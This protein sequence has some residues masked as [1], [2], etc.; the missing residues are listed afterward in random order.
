V[1]G[2]V[3]CM[4]V[5][6]GCGDDT[7]AVD[8]FSVTKAGQEQCAALLDALPGSVS[9]QDRREVSGSRYAAAYGDPPIGGR[10]GVGVPKDFDRFSACNRANGIDWYV[11]DLDAVAEDQSR[12]ITMTTI[13]REPALRVDLPAE[14]RPPATAMVDLTRTIEQQTRKVG[15]CVD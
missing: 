2:V 5:L 11:E 12:D 6:S 1:A 8:D 10:C 4:L 3:L 7:V 9:D 14:Y 13:G 15:G